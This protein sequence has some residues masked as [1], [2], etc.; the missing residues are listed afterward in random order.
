M[1]PLFNLLHL[2]PCFNAALPTD[3]R[4]QTFYLSFAHFVASRSVPSPIP[5]IFS[6]FSTPPAASPLLT[7]LGFFNEMLVFEPGALNYFTT[8]SHPVIL[9]LCINPILTHL[10][11]RIRGFSA[12]RSVRTHSRSGI[13]SPDNPQASSGIIILSGKACPL[14]F[15]HS[16]FT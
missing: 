5:H 9:S 6:C 4:P 8:S 3:P 1:S 11:L 15:L 12:L 13:L 16:F 7:R 2:A 14:N 10:P